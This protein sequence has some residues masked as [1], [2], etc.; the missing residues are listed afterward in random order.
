MNPIRLL[1]MI[2]L[3]AALAC[4][5]PTGPAGAAGNANVVTGTFS[6]A[7][8]AWTNDF[9]NFP[10]DGGTQGNPAKVTTVPVAA[11]TAQFATTGAVLVYLKVPSSGS[12]AATH[13]T[14]LPFH[15][16]GFGGGYLVSIKAAS[17]P[18][19]IRLGYLHERTDTSV[20][21]PTSY[22]ATLPT[23]EFKYVGI[24][25]TSAA[26]LAAYR[27]IQPDEVI[28]AVLRGRGK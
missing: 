21:T 4:E 22:S 13:W 8:G 24:A 19:E 11:L 26:M 28:A 6:V 23:Y 20:A 17:A 12:G 9:W 2:P 7:P 3:L 25:G 16:G 15:Q 10:V 18:G 27:T 1:S 14:L 5:G